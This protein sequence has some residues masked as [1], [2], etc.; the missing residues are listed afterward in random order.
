M[1]VFV[2]KLIAK[3]VKPLCRSDSI[4]D[5]QKLSS[6]WSNSKERLEALKGPISLMT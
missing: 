2:V 5:V 4:L 1:S 3:L 6:A